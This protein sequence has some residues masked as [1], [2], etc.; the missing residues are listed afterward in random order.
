MRWQIIDNREV[1]N[2][3]ACTKII[4]DKSTTQNSCR[5]RLQAHPL[6]HVC[7]LVAVDIEQSCSD[8]MALPAF[9]REHCLVAVEHDTSHTR[10][11]FL[12]PTVRLACKH[13]V[14]VSLV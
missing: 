5:D 12:H 10:C 4:A 3:P 11:A 6:D 1:A 2:I 8:W 7:S 14:N 9:H 13:A